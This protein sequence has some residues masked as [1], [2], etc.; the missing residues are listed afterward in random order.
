LFHKV[1]A[2]LAAAVVSTAVAAPAYAADGTTLV[3]GAPLDLSAAV[4]G[5]FDVTLSVTN[6]G[7]TPVDGG[8]VYLATTAGF[9]AAEQFGNCTYLSGQPRAC[10]FDETLEPGKSYRIV[11]PYRV[12]ADTYAPGGLS[13]Q[14]QWL[15]KAEFAEVDADLGTAGSGA[16][17]PVQEGAKLGESPAGAWQYVSVSVTGD[18]GSDLAAVGATVSGVVGEVVNAEVGVRNN[19][20]ATLDW[21]MSGTSPGLVVVTIPAGTSLVTVPEG[22]ALATADDRTQPDG[23][24]YVCET[25]TLFRAGTTTTWTLPLKVNKVVAGATGSVEVNPACQCQRF[26]KDLDKS[27]D[28]ATLVVNASAGP[29]EVAPVITR[30]DFAGTYSTNRLDTGAGWVGAI[31][32]VKP[33]IADES[34]I[35]RTEWR[36]NGVL[37]SSEPTFTWD[38]RPVTTP[39]ATVEL[40]VWDA[41]GN[42]SAKSFLVNIDKAAPAT[43][44]Y[45]AQRAL[46]RGTTFVTSIRASD[47]GGVA[48]T[49][50]QGSVHPAGPVAS[51]RLKSGK[52]ATRTLTWLAVDKLG[53]SASVKRT[54]IVDNTVPALKLTKAPKNGAKLT[55]TVTLTASASDRNGIAKVQLLVNGKVVATDAKAAYAFTLN[56][57]KYGKKFTVQVRAYD[58]AGNVKYLAKRTYRR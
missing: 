29:D 2:A 16:T 4:G 37:T 7:S 53:N 15:T 12:R 28:K 52:D 36:V 51:V 8:A 25:A 30:V 14:L 48:Y 33:T 20:P 17:L 44:V 9:E 24:Q 26:N 19:G 57:T 56:P 5:R 6:K 40:R 39:T 3:A 55:K 1:L 42:T 58:K 45:P 47:R 34:P 41:A 54:V 22:C 11:L 38:A 46:I 18:N 10:T 49:D 43:T 23:V 27:N 31:S 13:G 32:K 50:L 35:A 21:T